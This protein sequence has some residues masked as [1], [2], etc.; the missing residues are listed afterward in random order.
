MNRYTV[1][2]W[3][4]VC[5]CVCIYIYIYGGIFTSGIN[6]GHIEGTI[7]ELGVDVGGNGFLHFS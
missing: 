7:T 1:G 5:V 2:V 3:G 6:V 4:F